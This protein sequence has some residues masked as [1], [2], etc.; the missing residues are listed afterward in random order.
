MTFNR[1]YFFPCVCARCTQ[2]EYDKCLMKTCTLK[3]TLSCLPLFSSLAQG[4]FLP[5]VIAMLTLLAHLSVGAVVIVTLLIV[6]II[7]TRK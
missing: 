5:F 1:P 6:D 4:G 7:P 3:I 2:Q